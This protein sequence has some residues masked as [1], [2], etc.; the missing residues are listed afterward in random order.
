VQYIPLFLANSYLFAFP[1]HVARKTFLPEKEKER[2]TL[3]F[4]A[5][6]Q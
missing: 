4:R 3:I 6:F 2:K 1:I 5:F